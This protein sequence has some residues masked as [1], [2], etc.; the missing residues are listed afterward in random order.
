MY[1]QHQTGY[2]LLSEEQT[3][4]INDEFEYIFS[5]KSS[6]GIEMQFQYFNFSY[7]CFTEKRAS[8][9]DTS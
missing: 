6:Y 4:I 9:Q 5:P 3:Q 7:T 2:N 1:K 8:S